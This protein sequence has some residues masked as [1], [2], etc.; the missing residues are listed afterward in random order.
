L[1]GERTFLLGFDIGFGSFWQAGQD[2]NRVAGTRDSITAPVTALETVYPYLTSG[3]SGTEVIAATVTANGQTATASAEVKIRYLDLAPL[4]R[5]ATTYRFTDQNGSGGQRHGNVNHFL[6]PAFAQGAQN[7]FQD[8]FDNTAPD[9][10]FLYA[11]TN[12]WVTEASLEFGGLLDVATTAWRP[13]HMTHRTGRDLDVRWW[14]VYDDRQFVDSCQ[15]AGV[16]CAVHCN[17]GNTTL[18]PCPILT[19]ISNTQRHWHLT[20][21]H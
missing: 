3:V 10:R 2:P 13:P 6:Q 11:D 21:L 8:Y 15:A 17:N 16:S 4:A 5:I 18:N 14:N 1:A 12:F 7:A 9:E 19:P 20:A